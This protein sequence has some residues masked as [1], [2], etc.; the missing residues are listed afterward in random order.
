MIRIFVLICLYVSVNLHAQSF[1]FTTEHTSV[2]DTLNSE[3]IVDMLLTNTSDD[4]LTL[5]IKWV[6]LDFPEGWE[7]AVCF[8]DNCFP[9][10]V[11][12]ITTT[13][14]YSSS[15]LL[16]GDVRVLSVDIFPK[17][18]FGT[19]A[20]KIVAG[21]LS[22]PSDSVGIIL[23]VNIS[24]PVSVK[25]SYTP[26]SFRLLQNY[27]NPFNPS[28]E[29]TFEVIERSYLTLDIF[30]ISGQKTASVAEGEFMPG[31]Y[32]KTFDASQLASGLYIARLASG[33]NVSVIKIMLEK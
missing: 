26:V 32:R 21:N 10:F 4:T 15:P 14:D 22:N 24:N 8:D 27:P 19:G 9:D 16:P 25:D 12:S 1:T 5:F 3:I 31:I 11:D 2:S 28:T 33:R 23:T 20:V 13:E 7:Y 6:S 30:S 29:I 18:S 17:I